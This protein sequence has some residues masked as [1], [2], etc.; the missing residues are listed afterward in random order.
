[1]SDFVFHKGQI[2]QFSQFGKLRLSPKRDPDRVGR[3]C[4][5]SGYSG[6]MAVRRNVELH[7]TSLDVR[8]DSVAQSEDD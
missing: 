8:R 7:R 4:G 6:H 1:M 2:V 3:V 5:D